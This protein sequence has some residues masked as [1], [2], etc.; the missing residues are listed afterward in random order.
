MMTAGIMQDMP[1]DALRQARTGIAA[2]DAK[3]AEAELAVARLEARLSTAAQTIASNI[4]AANGR[5]S[6]R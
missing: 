2:A 6:R 4:A 1:S 3:Q 5:T